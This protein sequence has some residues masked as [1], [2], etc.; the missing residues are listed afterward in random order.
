LSKE[1][2]FSRKPFTYIVFELARLRTRWDNE[3]DEGVRHM[4]A[5]RYLRVVEEFDRRSD[6]WFWKLHPLDILIGKEEKR[7]TG[8]EGHKPLYSKPKE[9]DEDEDVVQYGKEC[10]KCS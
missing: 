1:T 2:D 10:K 3:E 8:I 9:E 4:I 6:N 7:L 5:K